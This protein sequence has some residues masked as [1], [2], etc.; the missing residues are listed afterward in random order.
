MLKFIGL[1]EVLVFRMNDGVRLAPGFK[2]T[3]DGKEEF[4]KI[5]NMAA[6]R[7]YPLEIHA[8]TDD[9]ARQIL[10]VFE[11]VGASH[12]LRPLRWCIAHIS[13][14]TAETFAR[15]R[16]LGICY[17]VQMGPYWEAFQI[18][19]TNGLAASTYVPPVKL[20]MQAGLNIV[21]G[22]DST[23]VGEFNTWRAIEYHV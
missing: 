10:D 14:G 18:A 19:A 1:G 4:L 21:G 3:D 12:D 20:A 8:Y 13:T 6:Q 5:A 2:A 7:K 9:A 23:R 15:M 16:R 11:Q 22:T 17:S